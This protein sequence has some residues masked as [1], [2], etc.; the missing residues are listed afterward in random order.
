MSRSL[1]EYR[2]FCG[3]PGGLQRERKA[4]KEIIDI[5]NRQDAGYR[6]VHFVPVGWEDTLPGAGRPQAKINEEIRTC[7][8]F[9][10][11]F[12]NRWGT[13][14]DDP[15]ITK[16]TSGTEEEY[17]VALECYE[18]PAHDLSEIV[19]L[20][21]GVARAQMADPGPELS[22][23]IKFRTK[24]ESEENSCT[25]ALTAGKRSKKPFGD[26]SQNGFGITK[27]ERRDE[28]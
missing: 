21:K 14:P 22:Q 23:V 7:D 11:M 2:V 13:A 24:V 25:R 5:Y 10:L 6:G 8:Y 4:F 19:L 15:K 9:L 26:F 18:N 12:W 20:F 16:Y 27:A 17:Y 3:S 1:K 28:R